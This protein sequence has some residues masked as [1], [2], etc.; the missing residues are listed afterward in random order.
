MRLSA[1]RDMGRNE[2]DQWRTGEGTSRHETFHA[3]RSFFNV[4][5]VSGKGLPEHKW[6][7]GKRSF[8]SRTHVCGLDDRSC[9]GAMAAKGPSNT[10]GKKQRSND[11]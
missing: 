6:R 2:D 11:V 4:V 3:N 5:E 9:H 10:E 7:D 8:S 1:T